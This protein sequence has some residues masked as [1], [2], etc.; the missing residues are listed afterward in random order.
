MLYKYENKDSWYPDGWISWRYWC[1]CMDAHHVL[2]LNTHSDGIEL[3]L[4]IGYKASFWRRVKMAWELLRYGEVSLHDLHV[5]KED[6]KEIAAI[7]NEQTK[8]Q[9]ELNKNEFSDTIS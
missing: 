5:T 7:F 8:E 2:E 4:I 1:Q 3:G 6:C 9:I